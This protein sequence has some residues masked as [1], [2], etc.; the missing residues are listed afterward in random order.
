MFLFNPKIFEQESLAD[1]KSIILTAESGVSTEERWNTETPWLLSLIGQYVKPQGLV[2]DYG[3]GVGRLAK[4]MV[5]NGSSVIG[6]DESSAMREHATSFVANNRFV[7]MTPEMLEQLVKVGMQVDTVFAI[8]V[9][10]HT[11]DLDGVID[12][13]HGSMKR[14][15]VLVVADMQHRAIPTNMGWIDDGKNVKELLSQKLT[16]IQQY[17]YDFDYAPS[18]LKK[19]SYVAFYRKD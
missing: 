19:S 4:P 6:V 15:G 7:A 1:A 13:I 8:W 18:N 9:L 5:D 16:L 11:Y 12:K 17:A 3:C 2:I 10:Q 14:G